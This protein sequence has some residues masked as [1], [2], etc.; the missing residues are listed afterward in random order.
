LV[1]LNRAPGPDEPVILSLDRTTLRRSG[2]LVQCDSPDAGPVGRITIE[3][4]GCV[5]APRS[6]QPLLVL[7]GERSPEELLRRIIWTGQGSL[8]TPNSPLVGRRDDSGQTQVLGEDVLSID[9]LVRSDVE[10]AG[11]V[12]GPASGSQ[13]VRWLAPL[14]SD[15]SPGIDASMFAE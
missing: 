6:G 12:D 9:G 7:C 5:L 13:A 11:E 3:T 10:F 8:V 2:P 4:S 1:R 14:Q 15:D